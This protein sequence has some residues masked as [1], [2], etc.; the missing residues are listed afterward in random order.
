MA[1]APVAVLLVEDN[2]PDARLVEILLEES[3]EKRFRLTR[4]VDLASA[5]AALDEGHYG[6]V[7]VDLFL[8]DSEGLDTFRAVSKAAPGVPIVVL[9]G[10]ADEDA[11]MQAVAEGAQDY[12][13]KGKADG[14]HLLHALH[15]AV[16]RHRRQAALA[17][18]L[19]ASEAEMD[20]ARRIYRHLLPARS[21]S[22]PGFDIAG[23]TASATAAGGDFFDYLDLADGQLGVA[24]GDVTSHGV[25]PAMLMAAT[26]AYLRAFAH[27]RSSIGEIVALTN[28]VLVKDVGQDNNVTLLFVQLDPRSRSLTYASAGHEPGYILDRSGAARDKIYCTGIPL[29]IEVDATYRTAGPTPLHPGEIALLLTDGIREARSPDG[30]EFGRNRAAAVVSANRRRPAA[31]ILAA[32]LDEVCRFRHQQPAQDDITTVIIKATEV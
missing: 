29:G 31:E 15:Y 8:P 22:C 14:A 28:R 24:V 12:L 13:I 23:G 20:T 6:V 26:R 27:T 16:G 9:T 21:P 4:A 18:A 17:R 30:E 2:L 5:L 32:L 11:G 10:L 19:Q 25:G 7:L 3:G 1:A